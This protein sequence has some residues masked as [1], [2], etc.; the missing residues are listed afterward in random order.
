MQSNQNKTQR[1]N[2]SWTYRLTLMFFISQLCMILA[3]LP[4]F[5]NMKQ[6]AADPF[7]WG[8]G[9]EN[10]TFNLQISTWQ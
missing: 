7:F 9:E 3:Y 6:E 2:L 4:P 1:P 10:A 8:G 5:I